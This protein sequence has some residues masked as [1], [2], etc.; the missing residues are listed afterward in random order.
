MSDEKPD[1]AVAPAPEA[2]G[3]SNPLDDISNLL[4]SI[5]PAKQ[6]GTSNWGLPDRKNAGINQRRHY[7]HPVRWRVAV[8]NKSG[9]NNEIYHGRTYDVS[10]SGISILLER[11]MFFTTNVVILLAIPPMHQGQ[12]ETIVEIECSITHTVL[13]SEHQQFR[14]GLRFIH[15]KGNGK[16]ILTDVLSKR[17][18]PKQESARYT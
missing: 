16:A 4:A 6:A 14:M 9:G 2:A 12:R 17:H 11:N 10:V 1:A 8:V 18:I 15:F 13:D 3:A 7:R 5:P